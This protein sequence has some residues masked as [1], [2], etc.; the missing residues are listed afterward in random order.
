MVLAR[1]RDPRCRSSE[2]TIA[3]SLH[4]HFRAEHLFSLKQA[5][6]LYEFYQGQIAECDR[7]I[8]AQL[9]GFD[10]ADA[11]A[12]VR[13]PVWTRPCSECRGWT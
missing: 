3:R 7:E 9:G 4:G 13:P 2:A 11:P 1:L 10:A 8:L 12:T 6:E 5:V